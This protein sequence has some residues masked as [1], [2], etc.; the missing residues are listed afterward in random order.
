M[1]RIPHVI[2]FVLWT[3][4]VFQIGYV[5]HEYEA[6]IDKDKIVFEN[7]PDGFS[8]TRLRDWQR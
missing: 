7:Y 1:K 6:K 8:K 3:Y 4:V 5:W 2:L